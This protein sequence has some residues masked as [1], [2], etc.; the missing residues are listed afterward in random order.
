MAAA[1]EVVPFIGKTNEFKDIVKVHSMPTDIILFDSFEILKY[2]TLITINI[3]N[4]E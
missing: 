4:Y 1:T 2:K 3:E